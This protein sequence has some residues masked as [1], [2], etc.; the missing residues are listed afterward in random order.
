[1]TETLSLTEL[2]ER[3]EVTPRTVRY[4][5][6]NGLLPAPGTA[7]PGAHY[8]RSYVDRLRLIKRLQKA[9]LPLAEIRERLSTL[10]DEE[11]RKLSNESEP[12]TRIADSAADYVRAVLEDRAPTH[13]AATPPAPASYEAREAIYPTPQRSQ[14]ERITLDPDIEIHVRR[15]LSREKNRALHDLLDRARTLFE[16]MEE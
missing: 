11:V 3:A 16:K 8:D 10:G 2:A 4:Y 1:M 13:L 7:G 12:V 5:I 15:P 9:H 6:Q 14:W